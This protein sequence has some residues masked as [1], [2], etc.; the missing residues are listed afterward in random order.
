MG[1]RNWIPLPASLHVYWAFPS[2]FL[3]VKWVY[4]ETGRQRGQEDLQANPAWGQS[5]HPLSLSF[6]TSKPWAGR[7]ACGGLL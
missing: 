6:L 2:V 1:W 5:F 7:P 4:W 3:A